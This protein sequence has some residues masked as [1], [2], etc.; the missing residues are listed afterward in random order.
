MQVH[1]PLLL[2][3]EVASKNFLVKKSKQKLSVDEDTVCIAIK[4]SLD[5]F[6]SLPSFFNMHKCQ[7]VKCGCIRNIKDDHAHADDYLL[8]V[9][10]MT[11]K[12]QDAL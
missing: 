4:A 8:D 12:K 10:L 7:L 9:A 3:K 11:N 6:T 1:N 2:V 5:E